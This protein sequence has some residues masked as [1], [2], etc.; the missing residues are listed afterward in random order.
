MKQL[1]RLEHSDGQGIFGSYLLDSTGE[2]IGRRV[3]LTAGFLCEAC[4]DRHMQFNTPDEDGIPLVEG[5]HFCAYKSMAQ[6]NEWIKPEEILV[7]LEAGF[8]V[9][10]IE[11]SECLEGDHQICYEKQHILH[12]T[13]IT[14]L[15]L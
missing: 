8:K 15:F 3:E 9:Y 4:S 13:D 2:E 14:N 5:L 11:V 10:L 12:K 1:I 7:F 6:L